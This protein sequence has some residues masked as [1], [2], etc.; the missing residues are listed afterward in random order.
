MTEN[1]IRYVGEHEVKRYARWLKKRGKTPSTIA[2]Q[3]RSLG[4]FFIFVSEQREI[5]KVT[6]ITWT[7]LR[8]F[9][10]NL[11]KTHS[12]NSVRAYMSIV[13]SYYKMRYTETL[14]TKEFN[15]YNKMKAIPKPDGIAKNIK[16]HKALKIED[17]ETL[18]KASKGMRTDGKYSAYSEGEI[19]LKTL[20]YTGARA[21]I[22]GLLVEEIDFK[23]K[24]IQFAQK[25]HSM[26]AEKHEIP[27]HPELEEAMREH[28]DTRPYESDF[29]FKLG[30]PRDNH[31]NR[32]NN[33]RTAW[34]IIKRIGT[35]AGMP[36]VTT[37][38]FRKTVGSYLNAKGVPLKII[39]K[40]LG[41]TDFAITTDLYTEVTTDMVAEAFKDISF[42]G[43]GVVRPEKM[44]A[45]QK[46]ANMDPEKLDKLLKLVEVL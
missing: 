24:R 33:S 38:Q 8:D 12:P 39:Q 13:L 18:L 37:H 34:E 16:H 35:R 17:V 43:N 27:L 29:V 3:P 5:S 4:K 32:S 9:K 25:G 30:R 10:D 40:L 31:R 7:D 2:N 15:R 22:Y 45:I 46:I 41:H 14:S 42:I 11:S 20:L 21:E 23:E 19:L 1:D 26:G 36:D 6:D 44:E 28:L